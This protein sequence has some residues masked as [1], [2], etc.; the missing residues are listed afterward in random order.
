MFKVLLGI[1]VGC[2]LAANLL[3]SSGGGGCGAGGAGGFGGDSGP[4]FPLPR[5]E[6]DVNVGGI[7]ERP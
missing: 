3:A 4:I 2:S 5:V 6:E 1:I 7:T